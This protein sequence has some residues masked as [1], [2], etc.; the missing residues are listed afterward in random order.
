MNLSNFS[1]GEL[2]LGQIQSFYIVYLW[3]LISDILGRSSATCIKQVFSA[4]FDTIP[5]YPSLT[6]T[7]LYLSSDA[8]SSLSL[9]LASGTLYRRRPHQ[10]HRKPF[11]GG[12]SLQRPRAL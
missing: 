4:C 10:N 2:V 11:V 3:P 12:K 8:L 6:S 7:F 5:D 1:L 9:L